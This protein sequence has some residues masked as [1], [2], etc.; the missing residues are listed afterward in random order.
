MGVMGEI[1]MHRP[2][3]E[4]HMA[5]MRDMMQKCEPTDKE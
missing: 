2:M 5:M 4:K 1:A 3:M